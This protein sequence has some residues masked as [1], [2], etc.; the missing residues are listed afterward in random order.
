M[1]V[2]E[3]RTEAIEDEGQSTSLYYY[4][5]CSRSK[6]WAGCRL[7]GGRFRCWRL[8]TETEVGRLRREEAARRDYAQRRV[9]ASIAEEIQQM[10]D[11]DA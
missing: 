9:Q 11:S 7:L 4:V 3:G 5:G 8:S 10:K 6:S 2:C 1:V